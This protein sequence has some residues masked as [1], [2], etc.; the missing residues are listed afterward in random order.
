MKVIISYCHVVLWLLYDRVLSL[1]SFLNLNGNNNY[2]YLYKYNR[3]LTIT[4]VSIQLFLNWLKDICGNLSVLQ[5]KTYSLRLR[6]WNMSASSREF[7]K[8]CSK[9]LL[10]LVSGNWHTVVRKMYS[11]YCH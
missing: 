11:G 6:D 9:P 10:I 3:P 8:T 5:V 1:K 2:H 7:P 4:D